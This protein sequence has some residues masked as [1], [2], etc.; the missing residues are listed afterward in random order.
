MSQWA[1]KEYTIYSYIHIYM[2]IPIGSMGLAYLPTF[3][4]NLSHSCRQIYHFHGSVFWYI[5]LIDSYRFGYTTLLNESDLPTNF[6]KPCCRP[7]SQTTSD[8]WKRRGVG[9]STWS[10]CNF[11]RGTRKKRWEGFFEGHKYVYIYISRYL[12]PI[13]IYT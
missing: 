3:T 9:P 12:Y 2:Y 7:Q 11:L 10:W 4:I 1:N 5:H 6:R 8:A 13:Y